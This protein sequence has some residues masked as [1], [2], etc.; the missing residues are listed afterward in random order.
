[1]TVVVITNI[2]FKS[3]GRQREIFAF[4]NSSVCQTELNISCSFYCQIS[5]KRYNRSYH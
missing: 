1:M 3:P 2:V 4:F 5:E